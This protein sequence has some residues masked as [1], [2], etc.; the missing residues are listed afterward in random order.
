[1]NREIPHAQNFMAAQ[2]QDQ[3]NFDRVIGVRGSN[4]RNETLDGEERG[5]LNNPYKRHCRDDQFENYSCY[6]YT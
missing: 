2:P 6:T 1:M 4:M 3:L 5:F